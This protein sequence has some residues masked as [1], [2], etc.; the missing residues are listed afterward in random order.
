M[1]DSNRISGLAL[2]FDVNCTNPSNF[3]QVPKKPINLTDNKWSRSK[4]VI[5]SKFSKKPKIASDSKQILGLA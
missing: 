3:F 5:F 2:M 4:I 1:T